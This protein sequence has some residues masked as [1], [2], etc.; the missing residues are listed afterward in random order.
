MTAA[1]TTCPGGPFTISGPDR[2]GDYSVTPNSGPATLAPV[3]LPG[4]SCII[5]FTFDTVQR[6]TDGSTA[7]VA[8]ARASSRPSRVAPCPP[9]PAR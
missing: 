3:G 2:D 6:P 8:V 1:G 4:P 5:R 9:A 7:V